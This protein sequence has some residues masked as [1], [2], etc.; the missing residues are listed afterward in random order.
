[1]I[2][3]RGRFLTLQEALKA[4]LPA[5]NLHRL[6]LFFQQSHSLLP[7]IY[8]SGRVNPK[9]TF[10]INWKQMV[11]RGVQALQSLLVTQFS[12]LK[13]SSSQE[14][15]QVAST[16]HLTTEVKRLRTSEPIPPF[17]CCK[18]FLC[19][20]KNSSAPLHIQSIR[21]IC[22]TEKSLSCHSSPHMWQGTLESLHT[23]SLPTCCCFI[24][25]HPLPAGF[26]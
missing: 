10:N 8:C 18:S 20:L 6:L 24:Q 19:Y 16:S 2:T 21:A 12:V 15:F 4:H 1:M 13:S 9:G 17:F 22:F 7:Q 26:I 3:T 25:P 11:V 5:C 23:Q 14:A